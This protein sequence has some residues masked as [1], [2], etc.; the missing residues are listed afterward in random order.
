M[1]DTGGCVVKSAWST[2]PVDIM[3][4]EMTI[5]AARIHKALTRKRRRT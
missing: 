5:P 2:V 1:K 3:T 4:H